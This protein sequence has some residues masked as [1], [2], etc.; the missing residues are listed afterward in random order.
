MNNTQ[1]NFEI[2]LDRIKDLEKKQIVIDAFPTKTLVDNVSINEILNNTSID[3]FNRLLLTANDYFF[4]NRELINL[5]VYYAIDNLSYF[6]SKYKNDKVPEDLLNF[7]ETATDIE[8]LAR[9]NSDRT[10]IGDLRYNL[11]LIKNSLPAEQNEDDC[12]AEFAINNIRGIV[13]L[14]RGHLLIPCYNL[15]GNVESAISSYRNCQ[16][17]AK[18]DL[19]QLTLD[20]IDTLSS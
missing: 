4:T 12:D 14:I 3:V 1:I 10:S 18:I 17:N 13:K 2:L 9:I 7:L 6:K 19:I 15:V 20:Y 8:I 16:E 11:Q 5:L